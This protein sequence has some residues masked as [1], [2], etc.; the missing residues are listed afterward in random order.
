MRGSVAERERLARARVTW[1]AWL[2]EAMCAAGCSKDA[3]ADRMGAPVRSAVVGR[4]LSGAESPDAQAAALAA[5][6]LGADPVEALAA[7]GFEVL[8]DLVAGRPAAQVLA[9]ALVMLDDG[10]GAVQPLPAAARPLG[11]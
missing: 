6:L 9:R 1:R 11:R 4:W 8:A 2:G 7:A 3:L 10:S 5:L